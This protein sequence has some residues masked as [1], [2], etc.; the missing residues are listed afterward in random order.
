MRSLIRWI[1][2]LFCEP[3]S[4][5]YGEDYDPSGKELFIVPHTINSPGAI[6]VNDVSEYRYWEEII[7]SLKAKTLYRNRGNAILKE[8][9]EDAA[10]EGYTI[11]IEPHFN[12]FNGKAFGA[13]ILVL[14]GDQAS[15][16]YARDM[17]QFWA[18]FNH[19][20]NRTVKMRHASGIKFVSRGDRG[21]MNL[22][23]AKDAGME[24]AVLPELF[25]GD[26][27]DDFRSVRTL[28]DFFR[29]FIRV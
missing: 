22:K 19:L 2:N 20:L 4:P 1:K 21:Y 13:E 11:S 5:G 26:N 28:T 25:F 18:D 6:S 24:V 8:S 12:A 17:L 27:P 16:A 9:L 14:K 29:D 10:S 23:R 7:L 15:E 3:P